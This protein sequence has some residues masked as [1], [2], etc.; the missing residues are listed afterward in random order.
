MIKLFNPDPSPVVYDREGRII[1]GGGRVAVAEL[2]E[3]GRRLVESGV[4][5]REDDPVENSEGALSASEGNAATP[6]KRVRT[7]VSKDDKGAQVS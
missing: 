2:D 7:G 6:A 3:V 5:I 1:D 4:L